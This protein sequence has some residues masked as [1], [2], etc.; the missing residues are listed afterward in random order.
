MLEKSVAF[1]YCS[2]TQN[3]KV[4]GYK[5]HST[6]KF[7]FYFDSYGNIKKLNL[8]IFE[9]TTLLYFGVKY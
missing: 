3:F 1:F 4:L 8:T 7:L 2:K 6:K 5:E 9:E